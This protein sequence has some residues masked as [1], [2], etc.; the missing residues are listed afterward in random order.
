MKPEYFSVEKDGFYGAYF[1][2]KK[3]SDAAIIMMFGD[4]IDDLM[5]V[6][7]AKWLMDNGFNVMNMAP[8]KNDYSHHSYPL[9]R[10][11][12][13]I[14]A[15]RAR[16]NTRFGVIGAS[17]TAMLA[18]IAA[19]YYPDITLTVAVSPGDFVME[20]FYR[21]G[22]DGC[23]ERPGDGESSVSFGGKDLPYLPFAYR[24]PEYWHKLSEEAKRTGNA[25][26]S[27]AMFDESERRHPVR[28]EEKIK[29]ERIKGTVVAV[30]AEDD[31]LWDTCKYIRRMTER[32]ERRPHECEWIPLTYE[33]GTHFAYP[34]SLMKKLLPFTNLFPR[35]IF[36]AG[37]KYPKE[38][39]ATRL[40]LDGEV[41]S[42]FRKWRE[43]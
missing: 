20:G 36:A 32:L 40:A 29:V 24:H 4:N 33:H 1:A 34:E 8:A 25:S 9:E 37:K 15:L 16:G 5:A 11:G 19:S 38:C 17:T 26:A 41:L 31:A 28:E 43:N 10:F 27:R 35:L 18:L 22:K 13:A 12:S 23:T 30:G 42:V 21:D 3:E 2:N 39:R 7:G 6:R 14:E